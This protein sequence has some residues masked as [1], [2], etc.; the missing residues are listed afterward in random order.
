MIRGRKKETRTYSVNKELYKQF[1]NY[2][3]AN[4]IN[5]SDL[6]EKYIIKYLEEKNGKKR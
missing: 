6:L 2:C 5:I 1:E 4:S 3:D